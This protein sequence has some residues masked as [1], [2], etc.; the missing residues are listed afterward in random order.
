MWD[1][2]V[3]HNCIYREGTQNIL[4]SQYK[5]VIKIWSKHSPLTCRQQLSE[6]VCHPCAESRV[7]TALAGVGERFDGRATNLHKMK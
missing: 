3:V 4:N 7:V 5:L 2:Y 6:D 1:V